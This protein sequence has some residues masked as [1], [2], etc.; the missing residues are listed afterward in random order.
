MT[1][2]CTVLDEFFDGELPADQ[3]SA[4]REH[5]PTCERC[6]D[7][8][9][10]RMQENVAA[11]AHAARAEPARAVPAR[12]AMEPAVT[13]RPVATR[14][15]VTPPAVTPPAVTPPAVTPIEMA[16]RRGCGRT[17]AYLA[18]VLAAAAAVPLWLH[19]R[20]DS[21]FKLSLDIDRAEVAKR[22][23][24]AH[25][26]DV[27]RPAVHGERYQA[28]WVYLD[29][30][31]LVVSCPMDAGCSHV[32]DELALKLQLRARGVYA[33]VAAGS[34]RAIPPPGTTLDE[35][36][37]AARSAGIQTQVEYVDVD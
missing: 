33:I 5:L 34:S 23:K 35:T 19:H 16:R 6:Q 8:L 37:A 11:R 9:H 4:F 1:E 25:V 21:G 12:V 31:E 13:T 29:D 14:P 26:G 2:C 10:G 15:A 22:G 36:L 20:D 18:P 32:N 3:A 27:L 17:L 7:V 24:A 30:R 28:I